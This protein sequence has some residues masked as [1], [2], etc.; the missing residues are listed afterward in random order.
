MKEDRYEF[1]L[2]EWEYTTEPE[3]FELPAPTKLILTRKKPKVKVEYCLHEGYKSTQYGQYHIVQFRVT[4]WDG[5]CASV[6]YFDKGRLRSLLKNTDTTFH[7]IFDSEGLY[8]GRDAIG[9]WSAPVLLPESTYSRLDEITKA[10]EDR[11]N[12]VKE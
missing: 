7:N 5:D 3:P 1:P 9:K 8:I 10:L 2:K 4:G 12:E 6:E 11:A